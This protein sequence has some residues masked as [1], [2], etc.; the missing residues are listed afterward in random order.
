[1]MPKLVNP[2]TNFADSP[3]HTICGILKTV[4]KDTQEWDGSGTATKLKFI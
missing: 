3:N 4:P 2:T 1:M